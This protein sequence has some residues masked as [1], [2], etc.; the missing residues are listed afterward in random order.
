MGNLHPKDS[1]MGMESLPSV[2][3]IIVPVS[4]MN[5]MKW[6]TKRLYST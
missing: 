3:S 6:E 2:I 4:G 1:M 5:M